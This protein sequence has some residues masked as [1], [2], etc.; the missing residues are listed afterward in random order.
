MCAIQSFLRFEGIGCVRI[1]NSRI[2]LW[3]KTGEFLSIFLH[4]S[5]VAAFFTVLAQL[6]FFVRKF[7]YYLVEPGCGD[8]LTIKQRPYPCPCQGKV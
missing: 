7:A 5:A 1:G 3:R 2:G 8:K 4:Q 6:F